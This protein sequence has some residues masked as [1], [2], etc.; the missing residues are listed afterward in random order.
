MNDISSAVQELLDTFFRYKMQTMW[1][2]CPA[3][4]VGVDN[5]SDQMIDV[6][7][8]IRATY[9]NDAVEQPVILNVPIIFPG[10]DEC[11]ITLPIKVG[12]TVLLI[13]SKQSLDTFKAGDGSIVTPDN[14]KEFDYNDAIAIPGLFPRA[15]SVNDGSKYS[16][17]HSTDSLKLTN[18]I[19]S[20][21]EVSVEITS[22]G[23]AKLSNAAGEVSLG[24]TGEIN[25]ETGATSILATP[26]TLTITSPTVIINGINFSTHTHTGVTTGPGVSGPPAV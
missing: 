22:S 9:G 16:N 26:T 6:Q 4:V 23:E 3:I 14:W 10:T 18:N 24:A 12:N 20:S 25:V 15:N 11:A 2:A 1:T 8:A 21:K 7:P 5:L 13:F 17:G 19:G